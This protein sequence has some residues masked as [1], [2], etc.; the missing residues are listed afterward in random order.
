MEEEM[1][2]CFSLLSKKKKQKKRKNDKIFGTDAK[3][4]C[5]YKICLRIFDFVFQ[6][7]ITS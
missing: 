5:G 1:L 2:R 7:W 6:I 4:M 3:K